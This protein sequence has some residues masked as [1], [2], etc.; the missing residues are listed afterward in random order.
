M[1]T[2]LELNLKEDNDFLQKKM[3]DVLETLVDPKLLEEAFSLFELINVYVEFVVRKNG[4]E[5]PN[6]NRFGNVWQGMTLVEMVYN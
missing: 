3:D 5:M 2:N 6:N 4:K 1:I